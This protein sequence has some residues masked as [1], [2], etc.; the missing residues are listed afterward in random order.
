MDPKGSAGPDS[1][2]G[3]ECGARDANGGLSGVSAGDSVEDREAST[4]YG[5]GSDSDADTVFIQVLY[6][7]P[8]FVAVGDSG[9]GGYDCGCSWCGD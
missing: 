5:Y 3:P 2:D 1:V 9:G 7:R 6:T 8:R 4:L